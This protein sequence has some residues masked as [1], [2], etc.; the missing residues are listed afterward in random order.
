MSQW[1]RVGAGVLAMVA[2][3]AFAAPATAQ[4]AAARPAAQA[5]SGQTKKPNILVIWGDDIGMWNVGAYTHGMMGR[6]PSIDSIA[7]QGLIFT[8]HYG[9]ASCT[10]GRAAF[11][12]GQMPL[13]TGENHCR[14]SR[15]EDR[16]SKGRPDAGRGSE[17][18]G[19]RDRAVRQEPPG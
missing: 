16:D 6:T 3:L 11:I 2:A 14:H 10:A 4:P 12:T 5:A 1:K 18:A 15:F 9:Q 7:R 17:I 19:L 8:D 13:R